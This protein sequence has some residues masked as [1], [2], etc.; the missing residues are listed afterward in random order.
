MI[1]NVFRALA[2]L[3]LNIVS[4]SAISQSFDVTGQIKDLQSGDPIEDVTVYINGTARGTTTDQSGYFTLHSVS[5]TSELILSH[6]SYQLESILL[7]DSTALENMSYTLQKRVIKLQEVTVISESLKTKHM[8]RFKTWFLGMNYMEEQAKI[9]NDSVLIFNILGNNQFSVDATEA[10]QVHLPL[11]GY[12]LNVDLVHFRLIYKEEFEGYHCSILGYY[13]FNPIEA[14]SRRE[15]RNMAR[16]RV[17]SFY[18]SAMHF[19]RSLYQNKLAENGYT[20]Q[21]AC[22]PKEENANSKDYRFDIKAEYI[23]D[24]YGNKHLML[25]HSACNN[26]LITY[27][28]NNRKRPVDLSYLDSERS[29]R[30]FSGLSFLSDTVHILPSGRVPENSILFSNLIGQK[31][32]AYM[33][34]EDYI[35]SMQ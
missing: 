30:K 21:N 23:T 7:Q 11:A 13:Y 16:T 24:D 9:L 31:G 25:T 27:H 34:P 1:N 3:I 28:E 12:I 6:V 22:Q 2:L 8:E 5:L 32:V 14:K 10:I 26:F 4:L 35:P 33:L 20:L 19:C 15:R 17:R 29:I 18:N